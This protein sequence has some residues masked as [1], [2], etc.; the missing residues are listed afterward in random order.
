MSYRKLLHIFV[1]V[2]AINSVAAQ[3]HPAGSGTDAST[4]TISKSVRPGTPSRQTDSTA[5][6]PTLGAGITEDAETADVKLAAVASSTE[7]LGSVK[8]RK[9]KV[10]M[11]STELNGWMLVLIGGFLIWTMSQRRIRSTLD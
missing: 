4:S 3:A 5:P 2:A 10:G 8:A 7:F 6:I 11:Q 1:A 9:S